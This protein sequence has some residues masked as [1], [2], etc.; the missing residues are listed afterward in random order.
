MEPEFQIKVDLARGFVVVYRDEDGLH[1]RVC[2]HTFNLDEAREVRNA[3][4]G[5]NIL[6]A[7]ILETNNGTGQVSL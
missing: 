6:N 3:L 4:N 7:E 2:F 1:H 5:D